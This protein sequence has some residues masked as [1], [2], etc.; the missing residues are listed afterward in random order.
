MNPIQETN[1]H[2]RPRVVGSEPKHVTNTMRKIS[3]NCML[4]STIL[5]KDA[6]KILTKDMK[7]NTA[8]DNVSDISG[9]SELPDSEPTSISSQYEMKTLGENK[10]DNKMDWGEH[11]VSSLDEK[12]PLFRNGS[13][14]SMADKTQEKRIP[15]QQNAAQIQKA[16]PKTGQNSNVSEK[17]GNTRN[18]PNKG[19][20]DMKLRPNK[21]YRIIEMPKKD[22]EE[23]MAHR[24]HKK[25]TADSK[26]PNRITFDFVNKNPNS[27]IRILNCSMKNNSKS[28]S[29]LRDLDKADDQP[30]LKLSISSEN[31]ASED[32]SKPT[33]MNVNKSQTSIKPT[34]AKPARS[35]KNRPPG[36]NGPNPITR[37]SGALRDM[38]LKPPDKFNKALSPSNSFNKEIEII[39]ELDDALNKTAI[40]PKIESIKTESTLEC[41]PLNHTGD[42]SST[43]NS[44]KGIGSVS[45]LR[46]E[47]IS[48][49]VVASKVSIVKPKPVPG[50]SNQLRN[51]SQNDSKLL[52][53]TRTLDDI[54]KDLDNMRNRSSHR[55]SS[56]SKTAVPKTNTDMPKRLEPVKVITGKKRDL[57]VSLDSNKYLK[58]IATPPKTGNNGN[59][60]NFDEQKS[61]KPFVSKTEEEIGTK[62]YDDVC[63]ST[64]SLPTENLFQSAAFSRIDSNTNDRIGNQKFV[65][66]SSSGAFKS[67][68]TLSLEK[69]STEDVYLN[70]SQIKPITRLKSSQSFQHRNSNDDFK[71]DMKPNTMSVKK[72]QRHSSLNNSFRSLRALIRT[73]SSAENKTKPEDST[74]PTPAPRRLPSFS[75]FK[76][77]LSDS[78]QDS[79]NI[80]VIHIPPNN[81]HNTDAKEES[82]EE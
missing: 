76:T 39:R 50:N 55:L 66:G 53:A 47:D 5:I 30:N 61:D 29:C 31:L 14:A 11:N 40:Q 69:K 78:K 62:S 46:R 26:C 71:S 38:I 59:N 79:S 15:V 77:R 3:P 57:D 18:V 70:R 68:S 9:I 25:E 74:K 54:R 34:I 73:K 7:S 36:T 13:N 19:P 49:R 37:P 24:L 28:T 52:V 51:I 8:G 27:Q 10:T 16:Q 2:Q 35:F 65:I 63:D 67:L 45:T 33:V 41:R 44:P 48:P 72:P 6:K 21:G 82:L 60:E 32:K 42:Q 80:P 56:A 12:R 23:F 1:E 22:F 75:N 4:K 64:Q 17:P 43:K 20:R 58:L 81:T